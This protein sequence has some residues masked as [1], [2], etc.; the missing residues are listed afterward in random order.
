MDEKKRVLHYL[1]SSLI[2]HGSNF[3]THD[4]PAGFVVFL[5]ALPLCLGVAHAS[6]VPLF[7]GI[8]AGIVG[9]CL[10]SLLSGSQVSVSGPAAGLVVIVAA[11]IQTLG[12]YEAF[13]AA[14]VI[15]GVIQI[16][17][18][19]GGAGAIGD[20]VPNSVI[21]G[22]LAGI[23]LVI[24]L[25]QIPHALG[26][27]LDWIGDLSF[28]E[29]GNM[30][31]LSAIFG[32][33][34][35]ILGGPLVISVLS[36]LILVG[37]EKLASRGIP[38]FTVVPGSVVVVALGIILNQVFRLVAPTLYISEPQ[39]LV[40][41]PVPQSFVDL[42]SQ[43]SV[44]NF[45]AVADPGFWGIS[46]TLAIVA[47]L[48]SLLSLEAADRIDPYKRISPP[49]RELWAQGAGNVVSGFLGG[50]PITSVV[51]RTSANVQAGGR[52][53]KAAFVHGGLLLAS[54]LLIPQ[55]LNQIP[56]ASL[57][58]I[59]IMVGYK[60]T[61]PSVYQ[62]VYRMG[63]TQFIPFFVT[64]M[65]IVFTDLLKG[66]VLGL[67]CGLF[68]VLRSNHRDA[69]TVVSRDNAHLIRLNKE[70]TF[71]NKNE[72][73]TK[74]R[75]IERGAEVLIDGTKAPYIDR[76]ILEVVEDFRKMAD[77]QGITV[78]LKHVEG[79]TLEPAS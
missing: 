44:P 8:I 28:W 72:L 22:M 64:V 6:G 37:W 55:L 70:A 2:P 62:S 11:A 77:H 4:G 67:V 56:L 19:V 3:L 41:L 33:A 52:T 23:G 66:V 20:Y 29:P 15:C 16:G 71:L 46:L 18:G 27:D 76:D 14:V 78:E 65:A 50:L 45:A 51:L 13:L 39:H 34:A 48:E 24:V 35:P 49:S 1:M 31:T 79:K 61:K 42:V 74:L 25:K 75:A 5:V 30:N 59:L 60:L 17:L 53:W 10:I 54:A 9:G 21:K 32:D 57:A 73:R 68:F 40:D 63:M 47:S 58:A 26:H 12:S 38:F 43:F 69:V 36:L 7:A